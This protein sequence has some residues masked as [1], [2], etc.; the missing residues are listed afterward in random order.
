MG[1]K[2]DVPLVTTKDL[3][4]SIQDLGLGRSITGRYIL[5]ANRGQAYKR[6]KRFQWNQRSMHKNTDCSSYLLLANQALHAGNPWHRARTCRAK[7]FTEVHCDTL[8]HSCHKVIDPGRS[9]R[10]QEHMNVHSVATT[11]SS[12]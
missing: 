12:I 11:L 10:L 4:L 6:C 7:P 3:V 1:V 2:R 8:Y 5:L 9:I